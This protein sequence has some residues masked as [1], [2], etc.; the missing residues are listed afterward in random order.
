MLTI[1]FDLSVPGFSTNEIGSLTLVREKRAN[2]E[3][4]ITN[5]SQTPVSKLNVKL[6]LE[7]YVGQIKPILFIRPDPQIINSIPPKSMVPLTFELYPVFPGLVAISVHVTDSSSQIIKI[8]RPT[9]KSYQNPPLRWWLHV[10]DNVSI[11]TL[12]TLKRLV[13]QRS[14]GTKK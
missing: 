3:I 6:N 14:E 1:D 9:D 4:Q 11:E 13:K 5:D 10:V 12:R 2:F 7:S 8:K